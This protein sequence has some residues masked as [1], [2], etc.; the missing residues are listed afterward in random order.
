MSSNLLTDCRVLLSCE[1]HRQFFLGE[2]V[3]AQTIGTR[4][5]SHLPPFDM[6]YGL[7]ISGQDA[8]LGGVPFEP[9]IDRDADY[10]VFC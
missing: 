3:R 9:F 4:V 2:R 8:W 5:I 1:R 7:D 10:D 6:R